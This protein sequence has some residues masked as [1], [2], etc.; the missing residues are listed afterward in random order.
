M[1]LIVVLLLI[2][3]VA[4]GSLWVGYDLGT[5]QTLFKMLADAE[6]EITVKSVRQRM[7]ARTANFR[8]LDEPE[9]TPFR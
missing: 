4:V 5:R 7:R 1:G 9:T 2:I 8:S 3:V 6:R